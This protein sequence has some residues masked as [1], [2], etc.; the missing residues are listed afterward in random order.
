LQKE[1]SA[2]RPFLRQNGA[3]CGKQPSKMRHL[4]MAKPAPECFPA[5]SVDSIR[6]FRLCAA[7]LREMRLQPSVFPLHPQLLQ[8][9]TERKKEQLCPHVL[10]ATR[11]KSA[12]AKIGFQQ[13]K[14]T[15]R[16]NGAA[17]TQIDAAFGRDIL[18]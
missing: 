5:L 13:P 3:G 11:Q 2:A 17:Q 4:H 8:I 10:L 15:L 14:C 6:F 16:L 7:E 18:L 1:K 12:K 9:E